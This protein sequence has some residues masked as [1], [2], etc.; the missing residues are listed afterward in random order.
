[1]P[2]ESKARRNHD[3]ALWLGGVM[4]VGGGAFGW[5]RDSVGGTAIVIAGLLLVLAVVLHRRWLDLP[6]A[7]KGDIGL[8]ILD[9]NF[10]GC[11]VSFAVALRQPI[12]C[13]LVINCDTEI[14]DVEAAI[15]LW[16]DSEKWTIEVVPALHHGRSAVVWFENVK[17]GRK[18]LRAEFRISITTTEPPRR[19][20]TRTTT[21]KEVNR[22]TD[23]IR[24][25]K[26]RLP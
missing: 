21:W 3:I 11:A 18:P 26:S 19:V 20:R 4:V 10:Q 9:Q 1:M 15:D 17:E 24:A 2:E 8:R 13:G 5:L 22:L 7:V 14:L 12:D 16:L 6:P 23:Q 25:A